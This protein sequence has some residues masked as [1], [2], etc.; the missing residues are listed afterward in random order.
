MDAHSL[1][2][3]GSNV[4]D[5][6]PP[7]D[8]RKTL[9][10]LSRQRQISAAHSFVKRVTLFVDT[11]LRRIG[12]PVAAAR[13]HQAGFE[14]DID[15]HSEVGF[16]TLACD[17]IEIENDIHVQ[18]PPAALIDQ[19]RVGEPVAKNCRAGRQRGP[20]HLLDVL[21]AA[22][23]IKEQL[24]AGEDGSIGGVEQNTPDL[25]PDFSPAGLDRFHYGLTALSECFGED[26]ELCGLAAA[27]HS[28]KRDEAA[29]CHS[30]IQFSQTPGRV[31]NKA[32]PLCRRREL[33]KHVGHV[34]FKLLLVFVRFA[35]KSF[36]RLTA[37]Q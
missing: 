35:R 26:A 10:L 32:L 9:R 34:F 15:Q 5:R 37:P 3:S 1:L 4:L 13:P 25:L 20:D 19:S 2:D 22:A 30:K 6:S 27:V 14:V 8:H 31:P 23:E 29:G 16:Q 33:L 24:G 21:G 36:R 18:S 28:F 7:I 12:M 11:R 17:A